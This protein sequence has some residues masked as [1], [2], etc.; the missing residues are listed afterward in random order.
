MI[1]QEKTL[2]KE[3]VG[4]REAARHTTQRESILGEDTA[5]AKVL[6]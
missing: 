2:R 1:F 6:G 4:M 3:L 5:S